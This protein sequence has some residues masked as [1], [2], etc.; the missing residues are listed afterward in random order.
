MSV[1]STIYKNRHPL[2]PTDPQAPYDFT[3]VIGSLSQVK[4]LHVDDDDVET[5][6]TVDVDYT[7]VM[8]AD[9]VTSPG[10]TVTYP[11]TGTVP[12][13]SASLVIRRNVIASQETRFA[14]QGGWF[15]EV[16]EAAFDKLTMQ[17]QDILET[18]TR[19]PTLPEST[20]LDAVPLQEISAAVANYYLT[21]NSV[22]DGL[23]L[24]QL[25]DATAL[26]VSAW[27]T[28]NLLNAAD[29]AAVLAAIGAAATGHNHDGTYVKPD[30]SVDLS[31]GYPTTTEVLP[32]TIFSGGEV[33]PDFELTPLQTLTIISDVEFQLPVKDGVCTIIT[34]N[35]GAGH[36]ATFVAGYYNLDNSVF[37]D[38]DAAVHLL[39]IIANISQGPDAV[40]YRWSKA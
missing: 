25:G 37:D 24:S 1:T 33:T 16:H 15:P 8:N 19:V 17:V 29:G 9:Q 36:A 5:E 39:T 31:V 6:L 27:I 28:A 22:G 10:G 30:E 21:V 20:A 40:Y 2:T 4:V 7:V 32:N 13:G 18:L 14:N 34:T 11:K 35:S 26:T 3:F 23:T 38:S 12:A